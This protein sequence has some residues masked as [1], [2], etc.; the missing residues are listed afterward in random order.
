MFYR[1]EEVNIN[2]ANKPDWL[3]EKNPEGTVPIL[4]I[5]SSQDNAVETIIG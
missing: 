2:L 4:E 3:F 5:K 1:H